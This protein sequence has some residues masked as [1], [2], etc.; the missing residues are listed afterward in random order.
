[1]EWIGDGGQ[2]LFQCPLLSPSGE[3]LINAWI[4]GI[5]FEKKDEWGS[6]VSLCQDSLVPGPDLEFRCP[7]PAPI[8]FFNH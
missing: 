1:M 4:L 6:Q 2:N 3:P 7:I 5:I 8:K